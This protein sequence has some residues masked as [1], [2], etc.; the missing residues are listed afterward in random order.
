MIFSVWSVQCFAGLMPGDESAA[1]QSKVTDVGAR[2]RVR[3]LSLAI[4][5]IPKLLPFTERSS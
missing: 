2:A 1:Y 4:Q 3:N 5:T